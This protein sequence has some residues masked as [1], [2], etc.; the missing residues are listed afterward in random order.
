MARKAVAPRRR[1]GGRSGRIKEAVFAAVGALLQEHP[2]ELPAMAAIA[3]R[4]EVN[5]TSLY[6]RWGD[7]SRLVGEVA[8]DRLMREH[9][10][11]DTG[12]V[13]GD[14]VVWGIGVARGVSSRGNLTLLRI[15]TAVPAEPADFED[16]RSRPMG[17]R[18]AELEKV[19]RR[20]QARGECVP[21]IGDVLEIVLA[22]IYLHGLFLGPMNRPTAGVQK[23]VDRALALAE[24]Q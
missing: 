7:V 12:S 17:A 18:L 19:L 2:A 21:T 16:I 8:V 1:P 3:E 9:P 14:L 23:L 20:G 10:I 6:R 13:R 4:A 11:R 22:P 24:R 5:P 15:L